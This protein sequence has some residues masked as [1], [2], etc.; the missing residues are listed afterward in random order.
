IN[1]PIGTSRLTAYT[2]TILS[3]PSYSSS[4][5]EYLNAIHED[6]PPNYSGDITQFTQIVADD[7]LGIDL[8]GIVILNPT[9]T[10]LQ[11]TIFTGAE[12]TIYYT[13][14]K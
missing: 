6:D 2:S 4:S 8:N 7:G 9:P 11:K 5:I 14:I 10:S 13:T 3:D 1:G 12:V